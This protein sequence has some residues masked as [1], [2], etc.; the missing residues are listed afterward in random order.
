MN[1]HRARRRDDGEGPHREH[2]GDGRRRTGRDPEAGTPPEE[3]AFDEAAARDYGDFE[4][5]Q[6][7]AAAGEGGPAPKPEADRT[8]VPPAPVAPKPDAA[9]QEAGV[10]AEALE[11]RQTE[12]TAY[13]QQLV[14]YRA[15]LEQVVQ[16][17]NAV[18]GDPAYQAFVTQQGAR[19][20]GTREGGP[21][22]P[23]DPL[24]G[25]K[26]ET[27]IEETLHKALLGEREARGKIEQR[28]EDLDGRTQRSEQA[29]RAGIDAKADEAID[30]LLSELK[31][32][33]QAP[34]PYADL[35]DGGQQQAKLERKAS[36]FID[37]AAA[38]GEPMHLREALELAGQVMILPVLQERARRAIQVEAG[39]AAATEIITP[40]H[41]TAPTDSDDYD[42]V[43]E[44]GSRDPRVR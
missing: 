18:L 12:L 28:L 20:P 26:P 27:P 38:A 43:V 39:A 22:K 36:L 31:G 8:Q 11:A 32:T 23:Q 1:R 44:R 13:E 6:Q 15:E 29:Q 37:A 3:A 14:G 9:P 10:T 19:Q 21:E 16:K 42:A 17:V 25:F 30:G 5:K 2:R 33:E 34:G 41:S 40:D 7:E 24:E 4:K 35:I